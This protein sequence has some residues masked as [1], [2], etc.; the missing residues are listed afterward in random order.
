MIFPKCHL[1][2]SSDPAHEMQKKKAEGNTT[3]GAEYI[4]YI[5][6]HAKM[7]ATQNPC[8]KSDSA[9]CISRQTFEEA[10]IPASVLHA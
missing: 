6:E 4:L 9:R 1:V 5:F 8:I 2:N 10:S 3:Q 7:F